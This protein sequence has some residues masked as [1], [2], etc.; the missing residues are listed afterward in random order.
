MRDRAKNSKAAWLL[1]TCCV[2]SFAVAVVATTGIRWLFVGSGVVLLYLLASH[3]VFM[4]TGFFHEGDMDPANGFEMKTKSEVLKEMENQ[5]IGKRG[6]A[7]TKIIA[8]G[9]GEVDGKSYDCIAD[10]PIS[11]GEPFIVTGLTISELKIKK[12]NQPSE[13]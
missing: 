5:L 9:K 12:L 10:E 11:N 7:L 3:M 4:A 2:L 13:V 1:A 8:I 6:R